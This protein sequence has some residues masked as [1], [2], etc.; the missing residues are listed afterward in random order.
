MRSIRCVI[1]LLGLA[2]SCTTPYSPPVILDNS[3]R[4]IG[5]S[6]LMTPGAPVDVVLMHGMCTHNRTWVAEANSKLVE[7]L[8]GSV[9][10]DPS[11]LK[12]IAT[13]DG[14]TEIYQQSFVIRGNVLRTFSIL[15]SPATTGEKHGLC[16]DQTNKSM[17][18]GGE[19]AYP[20]T[21]ATLN[22]KAK[23]WL[24]DDCLSDALVYAGKRR[25]AIQK[26][27]KQAILY[28]AGARSTE[29][30]LPAVM[31]AAA[32]ET[33]WLFFVSHSLGSKILFDSLYQL[34]KDPKTAAAGRQ[35]FARTVQ[36]FMEANQ[37]PLLAL[38]IDPNQVTAASVATGRA[39]EQPVDSLDALVREIPERSLRQGGLPVEPKRK[40]V[41]FQVVAFTDPNDVLSYILTGS[42]VGQ[43][44]SYHFIDVAV[45]NHS[46]WFGTLEDPIGA[47]LDYEK[48][49]DVQDL[50]AC[51]RPT[52]SGCLKQ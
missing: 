20:F 49:R 21:R 46:T 43:K 32:E 37:L 1:P 51:G 39:A 50:I 30:T 45:S 23:D 41:Q 5:I 15:W 7:A 19:R 17:I 35:T 4:F 42:V 13:I 33:A 36:V 2:A 31:Q 29:K 11:Q 52:W 25:E 14:E 44:A 48:N 47:H 9:I 6:E 38:A 8:G 24:L 16:Y 12:P 18:C 22:T 27:I 28:A 10:I 26:Q 34:T 40:P 3:A